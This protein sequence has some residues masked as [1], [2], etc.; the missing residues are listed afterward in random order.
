LEQWGKDM[1]T[2]EDHDTKPLLMAMC[3]EK[4]IPF[5]KYFTRGNAIFTNMRTSPV[6]KVQEGSMI[7]DV[8]SANAPDEFS[9]ELYGTRNIKV[10]IISKGRYLRGKID[11]VDVTPATK[12]L[13]II[14]YK[15]GSST[16]D[17]FQGVCY[18]LAMVRAYGIDLS[19]TTLVFAYHYLEGGIVD[20]KSFTEDEL[21]KGLD[22]IN[23]IVADYDNAWD[24]QLFSK[25]PCKDSCKFCS[26]DC[27]EGKQFQYRRK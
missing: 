8:E 22:L 2:L 15:T 11:R 6:L 23:D 24:L 25:N 1:I 21:I 12:T 26:V 14:D 27:P 10:P 13:T 9:Q 20:G 18:A 16:Y 17:D 19:E 3:K 7:F 4:D 5:G